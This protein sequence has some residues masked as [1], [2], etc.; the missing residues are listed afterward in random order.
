MG[1]DFGGGE[2]A[3]VE[4]EVAVLAGV[5]EAQVLFGEA[6][7][8]GVAVGAAVAG[9]GVVY[10]E[11]DEDVGMAEA[12]PHGGDVG[13]FLGGLADVVAV[14]AQGVGE[15]AFAGRTGANEGDTGGW[16]HGYRGS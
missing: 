13:V 3:G 12:L 5:G 11:V 8:A 10:V 15:G 2:V 16:V 9:G 6:L 14:L 7:G 1:E 4:V